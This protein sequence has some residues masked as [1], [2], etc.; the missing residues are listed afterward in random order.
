MFHLA[1][2]IRMRSTSSNR[3]YVDF[4]STSQ[5][6]SRYTECLLT[7]FRPTLASIFDIIKPGL[8][9]AW[10]SFKPSLAVRM[11]NDYLNFNPDK[12]DAD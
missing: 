9:I 12:L 7:N 1:V 10:S 8:I 3:D 11:Y 4:T 5:D 2:N 6:G